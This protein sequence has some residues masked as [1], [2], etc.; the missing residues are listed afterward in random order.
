MRTPAFTHFMIICWR[1]KLVDHRNHTKQSVLIDYEIY[2]PIM[3]EL[4]VG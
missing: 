2:M 4:G 1:L 3:N